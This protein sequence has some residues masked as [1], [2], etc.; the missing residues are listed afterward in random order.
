[1]EFISDAFPVLGEDLRAAMVEE[2]SEEETKKALREMGSYKAPGPDGY[3]PVFFKCTWAITGTA[4]HSFVKSILE[5]GDLP[6]EA[7]EALLV[8]IPKSSQPL[9]MKEFRLISLCN[10]V[11]KLVYKV[12]VRGRKDAWKMLIAPY[13]ASFIPGKHSLDNVILCQEFVYSMRYS[14]AKKG[15][16]VFETGLGE[17]LR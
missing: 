10:T 11:Y 5:G 4:V 8:L 15:M 17:G 3:Q 7:A 9:S 6:V 14:K 2:V 16:V 12:I 1:M 13:Q